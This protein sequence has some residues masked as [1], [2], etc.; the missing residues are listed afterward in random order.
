MLLYSYHQPRQQGQCTFLIPDFPGNGW[1]ANI[2][3]G[4]IRYTLEDFIAVDQGRQII[5]IDI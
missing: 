1:P 4:E 2:F 5:V 3:T